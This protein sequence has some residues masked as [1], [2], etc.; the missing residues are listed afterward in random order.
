MTA[1]DIADLYLRKSN[2][3]GGRSVERQLDEMT[4]AVG[5]EGLTVGRVFVDPDLSASR[6][7]RRGRPDYAALLEHIRSG[8]CHVLGLLEASRGS[9]TLTEWSQFLDLCRAEKVKIWI[10]THER[11]YDL[12]RRRDWKALADEGVLAANESE[13]LSERVLSG[14]RKAARAGTPA[15]RLQYG[16]TRIYNA[17]GEFV[18]QVADPVEGPIVAEMVRRI[19]AGDTLFQIA[20]DLNERGVTMS[21]GSPWRGALVRQLVLRPAYAGRR[22]HH[23]EDV[24]PARWSPSWTSTNG[25]ERSRCSPDP[26]GARRR[27]GPPWRTG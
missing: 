14:K 9:R 15:G 11:I 12:S 6:F 20:R 27:E 1:E 18:E 8:N 24:G 19:A 22:V 25:G 7:A 2:K 4:G 13:Q 23:G 26:S 3:D 10:A 5:D 21:G 16:F 17:K